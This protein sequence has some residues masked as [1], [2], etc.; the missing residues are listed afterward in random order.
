MLRNP[1]VGFGVLLAVVVIYFLVGAWGTKEASQSA[2]RDAL[3]GV[4]VVG[5]LI[6][7]AAQWGPAYAL[8]LPPVL[9]NLSLLVL[10]GKSLLPGRE[11]LIARLSR[12][13]LGKHPHELAVYARQVTWLWT[14]F[15][16]AITIESVLLAA[17]APLET[18]S[19]FTNILNYVFVAMLFIGEYIYR[20]MRFRKYTHTPPLRLVVNIARRGISSLVRS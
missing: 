19:L 8:F 4:G 10:F 20:V 3:L 16:A 14:A 2:L 11:P 18:W 17:Y 15:F 1:S 12:L 7:V 13:E 9:I 5:G 6:A